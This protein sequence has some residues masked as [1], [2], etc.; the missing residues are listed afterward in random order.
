MAGLPS[1]QFSP[2]SA[3]GLPRPVREAERISPSAI[4][5]EIENPPSFPTVAG[6]AATNGATSTYTDRDA[7]AGPSAKVAAPPAFSSAAAD[8]YRDEAGGGGTEIL[9]A[10]AGARGAAG[11]GASSGAEGGNGGGRGNG[12]QDSESNL[13][14]DDDVEDDLSL[15]TLQRHDDTRRPARLK[16][17][18]S[19]LLSPVA[20]P[21]T[22]IAAWM[23][24]LGRVFGWPLLGVVMV[25][26]GI[27]QGYAS[28]LTDL[29]LSYYWKDVQHLQPAAAQFYMSFV[30]IPWDVKPL[31]GMITDTFPILG[32]QR[33]P[34][35]ALS[36]VIGTAAWWA[37]G[38]IPALVPAV[39]TALL[40]T[41]SL[42]CAVPDVV[43]DGMVAQEIR[44]HPSYAA[45]LQTL[46][47]ACLALASLL[48]YTISG[49]LIERLGPCGTF[50]LISLAPFSL[51]VAALL[52]PETRLPE[53]KRRGDV[54][55]LKRTWRRFIGCAMVY[56]TG[57]REH[58]L[59]NVLS[60]WL[61]DDHQHVHSIKL[62]FPPCLLAIL[63]VH[64]GGVV[65]NITS[66]MFFWLTDEK[67]GAQRTLTPYNHVCHA[68]H[69]TPSAAS[70]PS[71]IHQ[72]GV[73][74]NIT[75]GMFFWLTDENQGPGFS[76][77]F[78]GMVGAVGQVGMLLG[79]TAYN[80]W[81]RRFTYRSILFCTQVRVSE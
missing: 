19:Q 77:V 72:G 32:F 40:V 43:V 16:R 27:N 64:Q 52:L 30:G 69:H 39:A 65:P 24:E 12:E 41:Q 29:S 60:F 38:G 55:M 51:I 46:P 28:S 68:S 8:I 20:S 15:I 66:G 35:I 21:T 71:A 70:T 48:T 56:G 49:S 11:G 62:T 61:T 63:S 67:Q 50:F 42:F 57:S 5:L 54:R 58:H 1:A 10:E 47:V 34:Y 7:E 45:D 81:L 25:T 17:F 23:R 22:G 6:E 36:G 31:Y 74:P 14:L 78:M 4:A 26:Y 33:W 37:L 73:V 13:P 59:G 79:V 53:G 80:L 2:P 76:E 9:P 44:V 75:S 18:C 3:G